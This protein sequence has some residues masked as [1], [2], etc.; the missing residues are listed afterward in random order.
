M[1]TQWAIKLHTWLERV[2][3]IPYR[4]GEGTF[5]AISTI[6]YVL[7]I[8]GLLLASRCGTHDATGAATEVH[9]VEASHP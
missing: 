4:D 1:S 8:V 7:L 9:R 5:A 6:L 3:P 2:Y